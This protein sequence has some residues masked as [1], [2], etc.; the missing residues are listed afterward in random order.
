MNIPFYGPVEVNGPLEV[1][2]SLEVSGPLEV[3]TSISSL[4]VNDSLDTPTISL[5]SPFVDIYGSETLKLTSGA[6]PAGGIGIAA[7]HINIKNNLENPDE[8]RDGSEINISSETVNITSSNVK[9]GSLNGSQ[10]DYSSNTWDIK[11]D[12]VNNCYYCSIE[13]QFICTFTKHIIDNFHHIEFRF[14]ALTT[15]E[16]TSLEFIYYNAN[17]LT[18]RRFPCILTANSNNDTISLMIGISQTDPPFSD[19]IGLKVSYM[20]YSTGVV[21]IN[22]GTLQILSSNLSLSENKL[23]APIN[24]HALTF[25]ATSDRQL[26]TNIIP[27]KC[28][29]SILDLP[30]YEYDFINNGPH[31]IGCMAQDLQ[32]IC[33]EIVNESNGHLSIQE[34]KIVYLLLQEIKRLD[35][36]VKEL[37]NLI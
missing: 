3:S 34:S 9:L 21:G 10:V 33:P 15:M 27:Y 23:Y 31:S 8:W 4:I 26:K 36:E 17:R 29:S 35:Q 16:I 28:K 32:L 5:N 13:G 7:K 37:K 2:G 14:K 11:Y 25:N 12:E 20:V 19:I 18:D 6:S 30:I 22:T 1:S 24:I